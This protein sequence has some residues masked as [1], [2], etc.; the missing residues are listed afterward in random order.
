MERLIERGQ[1]NFDSAKKNFMENYKNLC[2]AMD[3]EVVWR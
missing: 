1:A 3:L 2:K